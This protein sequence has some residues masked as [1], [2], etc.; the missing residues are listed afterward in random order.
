MLHIVGSDR[1]QYQLQSVQVGVSRKQGHP[2]ENL[3][4]NAPNGPCV[5]CLVVGSIPDKELWR[6]VPARRDVVGVLVILGAIE[7]ASEAEVA[8][9]DQAGLADQQVLRFDVPMDQLR[10]VQEVVR[11]QDLVD[12]SLNPLDL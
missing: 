7:G 12:D 11:F 2:V 3:C 8:Q 4:E 10:R 5:H 6:S 9:F 1:L